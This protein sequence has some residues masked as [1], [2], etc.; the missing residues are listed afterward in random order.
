MPLP[1]ES[2]NKACGLVEYLTHNSNPPGISPLARP[3]QPRP[4]PGSRLIEHVLRQVFNVLKLYIINFY[5]SIW[6]AKE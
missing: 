6:H 2:S 3:L 4:I 1:V 5:N